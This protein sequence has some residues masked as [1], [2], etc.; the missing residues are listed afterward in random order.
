MGARAR[1]HGLV[2]QFF[3]RASPNHRSSSCRVSRRTSSRSGFGINRASRGLRRSR[4]S[5]PC[6]VPTVPSSSLSMTSDSASPS[7]ATAR[8]EPAIS[9][10]AK[11]LASS[12]GSAPSSVSSATRALRFADLEIA[13][14]PPPLFSSAASLARARLPTRCLYSAYI[15]S[16]CSSRWSTVDTASSAPSFTVVSE[17]AACCAGLT[18]SS[19]VSSGC[20]S[21]ETTASAPAERIRE[22]EKS[23]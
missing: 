9:A 20:A 13:P 7:Y 4:A 21:S 15:A 18:T 5:P 10:A 8:S 2:K 11:R 1:R 19:A 12:S 17:P 6:P 23:S 22:R 14:P 3:R 16:S